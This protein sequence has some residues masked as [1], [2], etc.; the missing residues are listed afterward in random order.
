[1]CIA[2]DVVERVSIIGR[3]YGGNVV[4]GVIGCVYSG[5]CSG[6]CHWMCV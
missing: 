2:R 5:G 1:M 3:V 4:E 6:G